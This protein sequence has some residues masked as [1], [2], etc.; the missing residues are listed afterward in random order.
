MARVEPVGAHQ[1][2]LKF[3]VVRREGEGDQKPSGLWQFTAGEELLARGLGKLIKCVGDSGKT[4][5]CG[6]SYL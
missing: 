5:H 2:R 6:C 3:S 1:I 4:P